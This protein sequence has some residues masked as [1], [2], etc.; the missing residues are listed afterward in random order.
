MKLS[1][2]FKKATTTIVKANIE[3]LE[4]N[5]LKKIIGGTEEISKTIPLSS[6][7]SGTTQR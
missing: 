4:K 3:K 5:Q 1:N 7:P 6:G 2:V